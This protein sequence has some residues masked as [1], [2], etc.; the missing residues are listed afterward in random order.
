[1]APSTAMLLF[2]GSS[3]FESMCRPFLAD[4]ASRQRTEFNLEAI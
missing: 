3:G 2:M 1:M 4:P